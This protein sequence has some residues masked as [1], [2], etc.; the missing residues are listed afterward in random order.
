MPTY[1]RKAMTRRYDNYAKD[2][3]M[4]DDQIVSVRSALYKRIAR[5]IERLI[6]LMSFSD[7]DRVLDAGCGAGRFIVR[8]RKNCRCEV[9]GVDTSRNMIERAR[10]RVPDAN[11]LIADVLYLPFRREAFTA[12]ICHSVLWHIPSEL[13]KSYFNGDI[14]ERGLRE[15]RRVLKERGRV[16]FNVNNP[17]HLQSIIGFFANA[18]KTKLL[19]NVGV[20][21]YNIALGKAK[22]ILGELDFKISDVIASGYYPVLLETL[23][24]PFHRLPSENTINWYYNSFD[25]L[26][27]IVKRKN[28][29]HIFAQ[30]FDIKAIKNEMVND[31]ISANVFKDDF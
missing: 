30:T 25:R 21:T 2:K 31:S 16:L 27:N 17:F 29:L 4:S 9:F 19:K 6:S 11:Y 13:G 26:E 18:I 1:T 8:T 20:R 28:C 12:I 7:G 22:S 10:K 23:F 15:F 3:E 5:D 14:Y 24:A